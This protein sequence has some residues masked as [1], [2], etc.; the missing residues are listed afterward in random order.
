L[1]QTIK[2][3]YEKNKKLTFA[4]FVHKVDALSDEYKF[5]TQRDIQQRTT[6]DLAD[7]G[8]DNVPLNFY[9]TSIYDHSI[10]E[11]FSKVIQKLIPQLPTLEN[12]LNILCSVSC[13]FV[14][15]RKFARREI[16]VF[17]KF[18]LEFRNR[19]GVFI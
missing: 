17:K 2:R 16:N 15:I 12:L 18:C 10:F 6:D 19:K 9:L 7:I 8:L 1:H 4:V 3:A 14:I 5:D 11:A 13:M